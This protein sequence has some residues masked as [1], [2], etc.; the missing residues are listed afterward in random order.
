MGQA[1]EA[2]PGPAKGTVEVP[3]ALL[4]Q[5]LPGQKGSSDLM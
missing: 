5:G 4:C 1:E 3:K 2:D